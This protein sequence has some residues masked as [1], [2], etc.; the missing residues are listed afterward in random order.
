LTEGTLEKKATTIKSVAP[1]GNTAADKPVVFKTGFDDLNKIIGGGITMEITNNSNCGCS[2]NGCNNRDMA[3]NYWDGKRYCAEHYEIL[4]CGELEMLWRKWEEG[5]PPNRLRYLI[6]RYHTEFDRNYD[7][8]HFL[9][10]AIVRDRSF[11]WEKTK[12]GAIFTVMRQPLKKGLVYD[13]WRFDILKMSFTFLR[14]RK[15][16]EVA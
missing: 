7:G 1:I 4:L 12:Y 10:Q 15:G 14:Q 5:D 16:E 8:E 9:T 2:I 3:L 13:T 6:G 11:N